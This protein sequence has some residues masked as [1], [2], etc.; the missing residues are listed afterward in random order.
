MHEIFY[1]ICIKLYFVGQLD[2]N[3]VTKCKC[4]RVHSVRFQTRIS[5]RINYIRVI[6]T[7]LSSKTAHTTYTCSFVPIFVLECMFCICPSLMKLGVFHSHHK[8]HDLL[9]TAHNV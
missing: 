7:M 8:Q 3:A 1:L 4:V 5:L 9:K 6:P 2:N